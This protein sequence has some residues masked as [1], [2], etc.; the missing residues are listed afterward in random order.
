VTTTFRIGPNMDVWVAAALQPR[1][2]IP[3]PSA[4]DCVCSP[5][6]LRLLLSEIAALRRT[7]GRNAAPS[8]VPCWPVEPTMPERAAAPLAGAHLRSSE[9]GISD[10]DR[11]GLA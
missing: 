9:P 2:L 1:R 7:S 8:H 6:C 5:A 3:P 10:R 4:D 11:V